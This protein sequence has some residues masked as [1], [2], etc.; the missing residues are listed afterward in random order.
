M[1]SVEGG[2]CSVAGASTVQRGGVHIREVCEGAAAEEIQ[3][4]RE[5][6]I[7]AWLAQGKES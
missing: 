2:F 6:S 5:R 7:H 3:W 1:V 4:Q